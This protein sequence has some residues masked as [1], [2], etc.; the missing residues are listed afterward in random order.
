M[1]T[2]EIDLTRTKALKP[3]KMSFP[4][5]NLLLLLIIAYP[6]YPALDELLKEK[7]NSNNN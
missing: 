3:S 4:I 2:N 6:V 7:D 1:I 5:R